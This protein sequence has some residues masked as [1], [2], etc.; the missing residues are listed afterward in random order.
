MSAQILDLTGRLND[1]KQPCAC[2]RHQLDALA[3]RVL[4]SLDASEGHLLIARDELLAVLEDLTATTNR[5][6]PSERSQE[7]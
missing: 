7:R 6:L 3:G 4:A 2:P 5:L 1:R